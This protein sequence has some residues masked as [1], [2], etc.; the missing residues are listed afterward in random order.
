LIDGLGKIDEWTIVAQENGV[1]RRIAKTAAC[2]P[3][4]QCE[5]KRQGVS[6][7][8]LLF[9]I[10]EDGSTAGR[11][12]RNKGQFSVGYNMSVESSILLQAYMIY[13]RDVGAKEFNIG[14]MSDDDVL[15]LF[16]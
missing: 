11:I 6:S 8:E 15:D 5:E 1:N 4:G 16:N 14:V 7:T 12:Q 3:E 2:I 10:Y 9:Q 13:M